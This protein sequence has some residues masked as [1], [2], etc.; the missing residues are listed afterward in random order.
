SS[1]D[2]LDSLYVDP[3][4]GNVGVG[5]ITP[6]SIFE[7]YPA[8]KNIELFS[9]AG[10][11]EN[12]NFIIYG[13]DSLGDARQE[14]V[15]LSINTWGNFALGG[16][17]NQ[18]V[19]GSHDVKLSDDYD[20]SLGGSNDYSV[21]Y[22]SSDDTFRIADGANLTTTPRITLKADGNVGIGTTAPSALLDVNGDGN[23]VGT[24]TMET[25]AVNGVMTLDADDI[26]LYDAAPTF[27]AGSNQIPS[28][29]YVDDAITSGTGAMSLTGLSD[30]SSATAT[31][32]RLLVSNGTTWDSLDSL[33]VD[34]AGNVGI[35]TTAPSRKLHVV[36][37]SLVGFILERDGS[38]D[39]AMNFKTT[40]QDWA[41]GWD[42]SEQ[43]FAIANA[44]NLNVGNQHFVIDTSGNVG[45]GTTGPGGKLHIVQDS[46]GALPQYSNLMNSIFQHNQIAGHDSQILLL[47]GTSGKSEINFGDEDD[48]NTGR[49]KYS[50]ADN[51]LGIYTNG[52]EQVVID[53]SG[54]VGIG[55]TAPTAILDINGDANLTGGSWTMQT[56]TIDLGV[57]TLDAD[58]IAIYDAAPTFTAGSN[59]IPSVK[60]VD[61]AI[62]SGTGAMSLTGL[63][64]MS[65]ATATAGRLLVSNGTTWDSLDS[66]LFVD[67][68]NGRVG[69]GTTGPS[70]NLEIS[71]NALRINNPDDAGD[72]W[73]LVANSNGRFSI[74]DI[75]AA[76]YLAIL[77]DGNVG[78]GTTAPSEMLEL[79]G[80]ILLPESSSI[81]FWENGS[82]LPGIL[83][84]ATGLALGNRTNWETALGSSPNIDINNWDFKEVGHVEINDPGSAEGLIWKTTSVAADWKIDVCPLDRSNADGNLNLYGISDNVAIWRP[85]LWVYD[86]TNYAT[87]T[88]QS[89]GSLDFT[90]TG[91]GDITFSQGGNVGIGTTAPTQELELVGD[92][93]LEDTTSADTGVIYKGA[94]R[95]IHNF[96]HPTGG[97]AV[98][99]GQN[100][101]VG[102]SAGNLTMG[103]T[104]TQTYQSSYNTSM[105]YNS[106]KSNTT[107]YGNS[108]LGHDSL[109]NNTTAYSNSAVGY[110]AIYYNQTG[111]NNTAVGRE[112][113]RGVSG[114]SF[115]NNALFG[116][117][118][119]YALTTGSNNIL[120]GFRAGDN[121]TTGASNLI[122]GHDIDAPSATG[123]NQ[124]SIAN[125]IYGVGIGTTGVDVSTGNIGIGTSAPS[126]KLHINGTAAGTSWTNLSDERQKKNIVTLT[127]ALD[128][129][130]R[131]RG[132]AF[133]W[134]DAG[135]DSHLLGTKL[136]VIAQE[137]G[138]V[139]P[140]AVSTGND[141]MMG[142]DYNA[143]VAPLIEAIK[144]QQQQIDELKEEVERLKAAEEK[145]ALPVLEEAEDRKRRGYNLSKR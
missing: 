49:L 67:V 81:N 104:A 77:H 21:G 139:F 91:T 6:G 59:Q 71:G 92:L 95:F 97:G 60:Y 118:S 45:I 48:I 138:V 17:F 142:V 107:G 125:L 113:G 35:G 101:F 42:D 23:V 34:P 112:A 7:V 5:T 70:D 51:D 36:T 78:I 29:K 28:V 12:P 61:D 14:S 3:V 136:G 15:S 96:Q 37:D 127:G 88:A 11:G 85:T 32:G 87:A 128:S 123:N 62:T 54:N 39:S 76:D 132:V 4:S 100:T 102:V 114:N 141:G 106:F 122:I 69:I 55:I 103:S 120:L 16:N 93:E 19:V 2:S 25:V 57:L 110:A 145:R 131:L 137:V 44:V 53:S 99:T 80:N 46:A 68:P 115:S 20:L 111:S 13:Y 18:F 9:S 31:A 74:K 1:W 8:S 33:Y 30:V 58:N 52:A 117:R 10:D 40:D 121:L 98:P 129:V 26:A 116:Y 22:N 89:D 144:E 73:R 75:T 24:W 86:A 135:D 82:N 50:H 140:E 130:L 109:R 63:S 43:K 133:E 126:Y 134:R 79:T 108:A 47:A 56:T 65:S 72:Y 64:D 41:M 66:P 143:L 124:L 83:K 119:G 38:V 94:N 84:N 90:T 27:T 105:G